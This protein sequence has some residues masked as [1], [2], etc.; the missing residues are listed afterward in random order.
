MTVKMPLRWYACNSF[1]PTPASRLMSSACRLLAASPP[2]LADLAVLVE[3]QPRWL[4]SLLEPLHLIQHLLRLAVE[5]RIQPDLPQP[6]LRAAGDQP[7]GGPQPLHAGEG[8]PVQGKEDLLLPAHLVAV[9]VEHGE[10]VVVP[11]LRGSVRPLQSVEAERQA[12]VLKVGI[13]AATVLP[14]SGVAAVTAAPRQASPSPK[15]ATSLASA[16][17]RDDALAAVVIAS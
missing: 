17:S 15:R 2:E 16:C 10:V 5:L 8:Q 3:R 1:S 13:R 4:A 14:A 7:H 11:Q 6:G 9:V 12:L